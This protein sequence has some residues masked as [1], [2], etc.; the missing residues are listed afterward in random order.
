M[1]LLLNILFIVLSLLAAAAV[2]YTHLMHRIPSSFL[3]LQENWRN[4]QNNR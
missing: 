1:E 4:K 2:S 3:F